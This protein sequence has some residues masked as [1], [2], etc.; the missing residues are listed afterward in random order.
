MILN[1][2]Y[3]L[4]LIP[5]EE[6]ILKDTE[7]VEEGISEVNSPKIVQNASNIARRANRILQVAQNEAENSEDPMFVDQVNRSAEN[8][9][10]SKNYNSGGQ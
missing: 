4:Y 5:A 8:L 10:Q 9:K 7:R 6:G 2:D 3:N 1:D